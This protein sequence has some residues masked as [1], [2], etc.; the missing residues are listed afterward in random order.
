MTTRYHYQGV[1]GLMCGGSKVWLGGTC[2]VRS[3]ASWVMVRWGPPS[4][5]DS[6]TDGQTRLKTFLSRNFVGRRWQG[7]HTFIPKKRPTVINVHPHVT[8]IFTIFFDLSIPSLKMQMV[9]VNTITCCHGPHSWHLTKTQVLP[10]K[11]AL[12][13]SGMRP[14]AHFKK[15]ANLLELLELTQLIL[16]KLPSP[17]TNG[18][19][20]ELE[21]LQ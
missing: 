19:T 15:L 2:T 7:D 16:L 9:S 11:K 21:L 3:N 14:F 10:V 20:D 12:K 18:V 4:P 13:H 8:F 6:M 1:P 17:V 5:V